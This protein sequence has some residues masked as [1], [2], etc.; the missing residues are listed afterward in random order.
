MS[1][2]W[3]IKRSELVND[4]ETYEVTVHN[5]ETPDKVYS[6]ISTLV[7]GVPYPPW[8]PQSRWDMLN[9][10]VMIRDTDIMIVTFPKC[11]TTWIEQVTLLLLSNCNLTLM[12]PANKNTYSRNTQFGKIWPEACINQ[13]ST[14]RHAEMNNIA[15][16]EFN[17]MPHPRVIKSHAPNRMLLGS[18]GD[19]IRGYSSSTKVII[20]TRNPFDACVSSYYHAFNPAKQGWPFDAWATAWLQ[21]YGPHGDWFTFYRD[22]WQ[23]IHNNPNNMIPNVHFIYYENVI[24]NPFEEITRL[25]IFL[26]TGDD[27]NLIDRVVSA[28]SFTSMKETA[29]EKSRQTNDVMAHEH[30]RKG[31][32]GG[33]VSYFTEEMKNEFILKFNEVIGGKCPGLKFILGN[34]EELVG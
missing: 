9:D 22:Y 15:I 12:D 26:G 19:G 10:N 16:E 24:S 18:N 3:I 6:F 7:N 1:S 31:G 21:G 4:S 27:A 20:V 17:A 29:I 11:G 13:L 33:W 8:C 34:G 32:S 28:S 14:P 2:D 23:A 30:I 5:K 25:S